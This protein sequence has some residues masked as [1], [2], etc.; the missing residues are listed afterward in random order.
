MESLAEKRR[1]PRVSINSHV[2]IL[3]DVEAT[4]TNVSE[5]GV[6]FDCGESLSSVEKI[7]LFAEISPVSPTQPNAIPV[8]L[9]WYKDLPENGCRFG[10][11]FFTTLALPQLLSLLK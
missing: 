7:P 6:G 8:K 11:C 10:A 1:V 9:V 2:K 4:I 3:P 5:M